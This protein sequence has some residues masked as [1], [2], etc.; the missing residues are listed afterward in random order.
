MTP[1]C[2]ILVERG[3]ARRLA[4]RDLGRHAA[5]PGHEEFAR[6]VAGRPHDVVARQRMLERLG[7]HHP[8][9]AIEQARAVEFAQNSHDPAGAMDV[10]DMHVRHRRGDLA[11]TRHASRQPVDVGHGEV[12]LA[13]VRGG[14]QMQDGVG[15]AAHGDVERHSVL[16]RLERGDP[17]R[18]HAFVA[19]FVITPR[20]I[21]DEVA[22]LDEQAPPVGVG[23]HHRAV[24]GQ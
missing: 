1:F 13:L 22:G 3:I 5:G 18:Q 24:A 11:Q 9:V 19:I 23:R 20:E 12:D 17:A 21:D 8:D 10:L 7:V 2:A 6:R 16:E 15:R 14:E 4:E